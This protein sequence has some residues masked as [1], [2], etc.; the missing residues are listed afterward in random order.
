MS[1]TKLDNLVFNFAYT[2]NQKILLTPKIGDNDPAAPTL[3][4]PVNDVKSEQNI[5]YV[6]V[7]CKSLIHS[8]S[9]GS[10]WNSNLG[11]SMTYS[12]LS[13]RFVDK[14]SFFKEKQGSGFVYLNI[15][16]FK[17]SALKHER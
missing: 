15:N 17:W 12:F 14:L 1:V 4:L 11:N 6:K 2:L 5:L 3:L 8:V 9:V 7:E 13:Q 10:T 16:Q